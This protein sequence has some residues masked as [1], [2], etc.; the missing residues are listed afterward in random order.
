MK[1]LLA[2]L[3]QRL[4]HT[5]CGFPVADANGPAPGGGKRSRGI[6]LIIAVVVIAMMMVFSSDLILNS[7][8]NLELAVAQRDNVKAEYMAK[9]ALNLGIFLVS[10]DFALDLFLASPQSPMK[11]N[12]TDGFSDIWSMLNGLPIGGGSLELLAATQESLDLSAVNDGKVIDMLKLFDGEFSV[13][14]VDESNKINLNYCAIG[15][16]PEVLSMMKSLMSC[17]AEKFYL[18]AQNFRTNEV[19]Y[20]IKDWVD[21]DRRAEPET[22]VNDEDDPYMKLQPSYRAKNAPMDTLDELRLIDGWRDDVHAIFSPYLTVYPFQKSGNDKP[23]ININTASRELLSCLI[24]SAVRDCNEKFQ[25]ALKTRGEDKTNLATDG[26]GILSTLQQS[27]CYSPAAENPAEPGTGSQENRAQ[28]FTT[29][30][31]VFRITGRGHV[32][33]RMREI[34]IVIEREMPDAARK[35]LSSYKVLAWKLS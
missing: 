26:S 14:V 12:P 13:D 25:I 29:I 23:K 30:S 6:S 5:Q 3:R 1:R 16:C 4:P 2:N 34:T 28:W 24:P 8:V 33:G 32:G 21:S 20:K 19:I 31:S 7:Q 9:S 15:R 22:L 11:T 27:F 10:A 17:P 35:S 18:D